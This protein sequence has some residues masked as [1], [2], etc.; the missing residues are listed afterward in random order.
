[1]DALPHTEAPALRPAAALKDGIVSRLQDLVLEAVDAQDFYRELAV[2]SASLLAPRGV[3]IFCNVTVVRRKRPMTVAWSTR[4]STAMDELQY[5]FG[6]GPCL[7]AM[8][9]GV[10]VYVCDVTTEHRWPDYTQAVAAHGVLSILSVPLQLEGD[11]SAALNIYSSAPHGFSGEDMARA[12]MFGEQSAKTLKLELR[13]AHL[14]EAKEDLEA[15]MKSRTAI[16]VAVG[17]IMAQN[18]CSQERAMTILRRASNS[19]N[20]KLRD[21]AA[22]IIASVSPNRRLR[23]HFDE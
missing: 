15:A 16:D 2:F 21:V 19:R 5:A 11:S 13:L 7:A 1:M 22:G 10:T 23:T 3:E 8:R 12:E 17:V 6:D 9:T 18:R 4:L 14:R 20:I